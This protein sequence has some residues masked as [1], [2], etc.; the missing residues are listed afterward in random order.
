[1]VVQNALWYYLQLYVEGPE[2]EEVIERVRQSVEA[3]KGL[4]EVYREQVVR[5][6]EAAIRLTFGCCAVLGLVSV[7]FVVPVR[8]P[9]LGERK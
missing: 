8:L 1:L 3:V 9:R 7:M 6:Y 5:S 2:K 4:D